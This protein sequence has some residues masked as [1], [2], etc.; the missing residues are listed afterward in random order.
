MAAAARS[1]KQPSDV[2]ERYPRSVA[3]KGGSKADLHLMAP[4]IVNLVQ[5]FARA[6]PAND[7]VVMRRTLQR[8]CS[9]VLFGMG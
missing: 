9:L 2:A 8:E 1:K 3:L 4:P 7:F 5:K 6:C